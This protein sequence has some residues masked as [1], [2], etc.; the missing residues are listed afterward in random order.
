MFK[1]VIVLSRIP[2]SF[3]SSGFIARVL[4]CHSTRL[5]RFVQ[6]RH[7]RV[8]DTYIH[9]SWTFENIPGLSNI[10]YKVRRPVTV[11]LPLR[12]VMFF[13]FYKGIV[14]QL[15]LDK[16]HLAFVNP[17]CMKKKKKNRYIYIFIYNCFRY[18]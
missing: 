4:F 18:R 6:V 9:V 3:G 10:D 16:I 17:E 13:F 1:V 12:W 14:C 15:L 5:F 11:M 7:E 8:Y 2:V